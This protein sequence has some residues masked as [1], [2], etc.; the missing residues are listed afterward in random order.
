MK[1]RDGSIIIRIRFNGDDLKK[2]Q[3]ALW[4]LRPAFDLNCQAGI[5]EKPPPLLRSPFFFGFAKAVGT[6]QEPSSFVDT[7]SSAG[8]VLREDQASL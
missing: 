2:G 3:I 4:V 6:G 1:R 8:L 5:E 7:N